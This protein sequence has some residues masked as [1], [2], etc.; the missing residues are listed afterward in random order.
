MLLNCNFVFSRRKMRKDLMM[1]VKQKGLRKRKELKVQKRALK[2]KL[3]EKEQVTVVRKHRP[4]MSTTVL[5][6][7]TTTGGPTR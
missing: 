7:P 4:R 2:E 6:L 3:K 5:G 1:R